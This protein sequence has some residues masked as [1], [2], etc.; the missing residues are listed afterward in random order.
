M[1]RT[2][3]WIV[4]SPLRHLGDVECIRRS[5]FSSTNA[6]TAVDGKIAYRCTYQDKPGMLKRF[7]VSIKRPL[8]WGYDFRISRILPCQCHWHKLLGAI[9]VCS[10]LFKYATNNV[11]S[12]FPESMSWNKIPSTP[13][14]QTGCCHWGGASIF[15]RKR[16]ENG[17][18]VKLFL[19]APQRL[20]K[21][22]AGLLW[23]FTYY[24]SFM[25]PGAWHLILLNVQDR[26]NKLVSWVL[27][28]TIEA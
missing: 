1:A 7:K 28:G 10:H 18:Q 2:G 20:E 26:M 16:N 24:I 17:M 8:F 27:W 5:C 3:S 13:S 22:F 11:H 14:F 23:K 21:R 15:W 6:A 9:D 25:A 4:I 19:R 12:R